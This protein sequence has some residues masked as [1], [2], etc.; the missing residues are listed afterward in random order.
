MFDRQVLLEIYFTSKS[1]VLLKRGVAEGL[2]AGP[3]ERATVYSF[4][5]HAAR[6]GAKF[7]ACSQARS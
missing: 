6:H 2:F 3:R 5:Q 7:F 1:V 4:M